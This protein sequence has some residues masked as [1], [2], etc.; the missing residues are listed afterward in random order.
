M[1][2]VLCAGMR[3]Q[4]ADV[5]DRS[6]AAFLQC[7]EASLGAV[8]RAIKSDVDN[9]AP[10]GILHLSKRFFSS[11][12]R[13]VDEDI[14]APE[15]LESRIYHS[16]HRYRIGYIAD[17]NQRLPPFAWISPATASASAR[18]TRAF[19]TMEAP[20]SASASAV[21]RPMLRPEPVMIATLP[22]SS[23]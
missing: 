8:E 18:L 2:A 20:P 9:S 3:A 22:L 14:D 6:S 1:G 13:I 17:L 4:A 23:L 16:M 12:C 11:Q 10:V 19:T 15:M 21:A 5:D 7:R